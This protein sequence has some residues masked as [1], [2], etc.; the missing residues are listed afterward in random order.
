M[1]QVGIYDSKNEGDDGGYANPVIGIDDPCHQSHGAS[2]S[3][4]G[5]AESFRAW[6]SY[7]FQEA[8]TLHF[9]GH[10]FYLCLDCAVAH[11]D[12]SISDALHGLCNV[13]RTP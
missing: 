4:T 1:R 13:R 12:D 2:A 7:I 6:F 10:T 11:H 8:G 3:L 5:H 9:C